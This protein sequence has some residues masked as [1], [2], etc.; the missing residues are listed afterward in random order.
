MIRHIFA[1]RLKLLLDALSPIDHKHPLV[2]FAFCEIAD[3]LSPEMDRIK[4]LLHLIHLPAPMKLREQL[5]RRGAP[6]ALSAKSTKDEKVSDIQV[7][8]VVR[9]FFVDNGKA[10][11]RTIDANEKW[12]LLG[13]VPKTAD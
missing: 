11:N 10:S 9:H 3:H 12:K 7:R 1:L 2:E 5:M 4:I 13:V 6:N 8:L